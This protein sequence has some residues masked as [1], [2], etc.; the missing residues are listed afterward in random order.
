VA[1]FELDEHRCLLLLT[2]VRVVDLWVEWNQYDI[3]TCNV[4]E[5]LREAALL[6]SLRP[7]HQ[8]VVVVWQAVFEVT[9]EARVAV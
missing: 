5:D 8:V 7:P 3:V 4:I 1:R 6:L 9:D 2:L